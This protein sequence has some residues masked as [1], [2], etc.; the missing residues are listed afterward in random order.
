MIAKIAGYASE[1]M[2]AIG[3]LTLLAVVLSG[4]TPAP[5]GTSGTIAEVEGAPCSVPPALVAG[6]H[7]GPV[8]VCLGPGASLPGEPDVYVPPPL[9]TPRR[10]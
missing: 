4:C 9:V 8:L 3:A 10:P 7:A 2:T 6:G 5:N 1:A